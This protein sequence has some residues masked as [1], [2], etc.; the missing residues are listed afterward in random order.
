MTPAA[1][2]R[3]TG[4][5]LPRYAG[6]AARAALAIAYPLAILC[7]WHGLAPR[8]VGCLLLALL[9][10]QRTVGKGPFAAALNRLATLDWCVAA[11]LTGMSVAIAVT[12]SARLL[13]L[14]P[15]CVSAGLLAAFGATLWRGPSMIEKFARLNHPDPA[16]AVVRYTRR[17]TQVWCAFFVLN[18]AF[19]V[20]TALYWS[21]AAWALYNGAIAYVLIGALIAGEWVWRRL[22]VTGRQAGAGAA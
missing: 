7:A 18:G 9:W 12:D 1:R 10:L 17:V 4:P 6:A 21:H 16:P 3:A 2:M 13:H 20:Y 22:F 14:Y 15:A 19:S 5:V 11:A 8:Y